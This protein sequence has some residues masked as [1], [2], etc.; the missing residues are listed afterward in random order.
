[1]EDRASAPRKERT[2]TLK[3]CCTGKSGI[4]KDQESDIYHRIKKITI[5][6]FG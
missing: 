5:S 6:G 3:W 2:N 4:R 1:M